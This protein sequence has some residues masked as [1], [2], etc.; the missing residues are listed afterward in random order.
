MMRLLSFIFSLALLVVV[1]P[2][3][4][5][6]EFLLTSQQSQEITGTMKRCLTASYFNGEQNAD[7]YRDV[8]NAKSFGM[9]NV[10]AS[11]LSTWW[12]N[13]KTG[14]SMKGA[15]TFHQQY[16]GFFMDS[17]G[18]LFKL[19]PD[20]HFGSDGWCAL[21]KANRSQ[22][23]AT[24]TVFYYH[25]HHA[26]TAAHVLKQDT[27]IMESACPA[28][29]RVQVCRVGAFNAFKAYK[30]PIVDVD[31]GNIRIDGEAESA[32]VASASLLENVVQCDGANDY[33]TLQTDNERATITER[34]AKLKAKFK[35][36]VNAVMAVNKLKK[37]I[38][39]GATTT[40]SSTF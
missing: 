28:D 11:W 4:C 26:W 37:G 3:K 13:I 19:N 30:Y 32:R 24:F 35:G 16:E 10:A 36:A 2:T 18:D 9:L 7:C 29:Q 20:P 33:Q 1:Q 17:S 21:S 8:L 5:Q 39:Q 31:T 25:W 14:N 27:F 38:K 12:N 22:I 34:R 40:P 6:A 23:I 15:N